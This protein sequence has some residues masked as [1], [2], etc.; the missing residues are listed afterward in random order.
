[1]SLSSGHAHGSS[2]GEIFSICREILIH[3]QIL[4]YHKDT[5][6]TWSNRATKTKMRR[7]ISRNK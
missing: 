6:F 4:S 7:L 5:Q 1:M 3:K 2:G